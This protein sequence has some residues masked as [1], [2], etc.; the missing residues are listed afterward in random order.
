MHLHADLINTAELYARPVLGSARRRHRV[1]RGQAL[2][3]LRPGQRADLS[4]G[5]RRDQPCSWRSG[6]TPA[7]V[8][9]AAD[10]R[11]GRRFSSAC[12]R[13]MRRCWPVADFPPRDA[14]ALRRCVSAG[15]ALPAELGRR[16]R[17]RTGVDI[18]D[19]LGS[20]EMLHIFLSNRPG[21]VR[22]GTTGKPVPATPCASSTRRANAV[23]H[24]R[25]RRAAGQRADEFAVLLEQSRREPRD[26]SRAVDQ[27]R[28][29]V[30]RR[31][32]RL[33]HLLRPLRRHAQGR[34]RV[35]LALRGRGGAGQPRGRAR[36]RGRR[37]RRR[38]RADQAQ[39]V[40]RGQARTTT[41]SPALAPRS[42]RTTSRRGSR[43]TS[44]RA[45]SNSSRELPKTATGKIQR[46]K[47][48]AQRVT[49]RSR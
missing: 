7:A 1:L 9:Q 27:E 41:G 36:S 45:G 6:P 19:G 15:E 10:R 2:F 29:Q 48:R 4:A 21:D 11:S 23:A 46:F 47:L 28:R 16:W 49:S 31:R 32:R 43:R 37:P 34:R 3:R 22:Y 42:C 8:F 25:D 39:G 5:G 26:F 38:E 12:R 35:R 20:T 18:L 13:C 17:E 40:H 24:R 33:L 14:L 30:H 44:I